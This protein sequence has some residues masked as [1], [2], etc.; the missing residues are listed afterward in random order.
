MGARLTAVVAEGDR[1]RIYLSPA[2]EHETAALQAKPEWKPDVE[3]FQQALGF[4]VGNYGMKKWSDLFTPRQL[5]ALTTFSDLVQEAREQ[6]RRDALAAGVVD[7]GEALHDGGT[8]ATAYTEAAGVYLAFAI[9]KV[10]DRGSTLGRWDPT[11]T[12]SGIVN[13]FS[14]QALAMTWN[15]AEANPLGGAS[16]NYKS[17]VDLVAKVLVRESAQT[18][19]HAKQDGA[20]AQSTSIGRIVSTDPPYYDN[21]GY[22]DLSDYFYV[23]LRRSLRSVFPELFA[24]LAVPK[25]EELVA[26]PSRHGDRQKAESFFLHGMTRAVQRLAEQAHPGFR[27]LSTMPSSN[28]KQREMPGR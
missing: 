14:R 28:R 2:Q 1:G 25:I 10:A 3:F 12:Q 18:C 13:T 23:W 21:I 5:V 8:D 11:P 7:D 19:G 20:G 24:T 17:A 15:F 4:R 26:T 6:M 27:S 9:D 22:A 16:G